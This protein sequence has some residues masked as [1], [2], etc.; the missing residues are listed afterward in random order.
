MGDARSGPVRLSFNLHLRV[1]FPG[2]AVTS[3]AGLL[4]LRELDEHFGLSALIE[5]HL[6]DPRTGRNFQFV[7]PDLFHIG[8]PG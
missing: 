1:E 5:R 7:L 8:N 6:T 4:L 3:D 2:A